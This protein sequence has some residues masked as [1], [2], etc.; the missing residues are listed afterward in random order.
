M[1]HNRK[2]QHV[3]QNK[4]TLVSTH[5]TNGTIEPHGI[6][7]NISTGVSHILSPD[8]LFPKKT[9]PDP[10]NQWY[11]LFNM[12]R[13]HSKTNHKVFP[14]VRNHCQGHIDQKKQQQVTEAA[15]NVTPISTMSGENKNE[16]IFQVF[17]PTW[18]IYYDLTG[19]LP[20]QSDRGN[21]GIV[22]E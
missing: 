5:Q 3:T 16:I 2:I 9:H 13:S 18:K 10:G 12:D 11:I 17:D 14:R 22:V 7:P 19:K 15:A 21:N 8:P 6:S 1:I 20:V 4:Q